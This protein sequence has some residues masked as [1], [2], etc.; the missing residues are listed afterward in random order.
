[1]IQNYR[2]LLWPVL[3][4]SIALCGVLIYKYSR[5]PDAKQRFGTNRPQANSRNLAGQPTSKRIEYV[6][7]RAL[8]PRLLESL[9]TLGDRLEKP[10]KERLTLAGTLTRIDEGEPTAVVAT[11]EFPDRLRLTMQRGAQSR[12]ITFN[13]GQV[14]GID[15]TLD[16]RERDLVETLLYDTVEH[17]FSAQGEGAAT[18]FLGSHFRADD[19]TQANYTGPFYDIYQTTEDLGF[20]ETL[21]QQ[22]KVYC[23]NSETQLLE[24]VA[25]QVE[26]SKI[27]VEI[28]MS[29]WSQIQDQRVPMRIVRKAQGQTV[30]TF[31]VNSVS[32]GPKLDDGIFAG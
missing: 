23:F 6:R 22:T 19:G 24:R 30:L 18:R 7:R 1:M 14:R 16:G 28:L 27:P 2:K 8:Q 4:L 5:I 10:G 15:G 26:S 29:S 11:L 13:E 25:Y 20:G 21:R 9:N 31:V 12:V 3:A 32:L 17:F